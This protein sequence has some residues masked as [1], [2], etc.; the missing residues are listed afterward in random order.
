MVKGFHEGGMRISAVPCEG[1]PFSRSMIPEDATIYALLMLA[2]QPVDGNGKVVPIPKS[3]GSFALPESVLAQTSTETG[4][5]RIEDKSLYE[6][7]YNS[8]AVPLTHPCWVRCEPEYRAAALHAREG[9]RGEISV[10]PGSESTASF[11][12]MVK[13]KQRSSAGSV[14]SLGK[15]TS[16]HNVINPLFS[17]GLKPARKPPQSSSE[18]DLVHLDDSNGLGEA[19]CRSSPAMYHELFCSA[20]PDRIPREARSS[21]T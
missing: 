14:A 13:A 15:Q 1:S 19:F 16:E 2:G 21:E 6:A 10:C 3:G 12:F 7:A 20:E 5:K 17:A 8:P 4:M 11:S 9:N 18:L